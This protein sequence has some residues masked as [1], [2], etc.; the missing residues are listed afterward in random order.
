M[1]DKLGGIITRIVKEDADDGFKDDE[2]VVLLILKKI[3]AQNEEKYENKKQ[4]SADQENE[5]ISV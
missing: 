4:F 2:L 5:L 3:L 1:S